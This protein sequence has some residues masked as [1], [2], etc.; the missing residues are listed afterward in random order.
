MG[1]GYGTASEDTGWHQVNMQYKN[2]DT[3]TH[4]FRLDRADDTA[5]S[6]SAASC[7]QAI[8]EASYSGSNSGENFIG[9]VA[10]ILYYQTNSGTLVDRD[11]V[12]TYLHNKY[13]L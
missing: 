7:D 10:A 11:A 3:S 1:L 4:V 8:N 9:K 5:T 12:E 6:A 13:R 2:G